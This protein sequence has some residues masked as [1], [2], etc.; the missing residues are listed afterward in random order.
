MPLAS[1]V[2]FHLGME[3]ANLN[4][5]DKYF[6]EDELLIPDQKVQCGQL[7]FRW[8]PQGLER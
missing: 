2:G 7:K 8:S 5:K 4:L 3:K 6:P 1:G